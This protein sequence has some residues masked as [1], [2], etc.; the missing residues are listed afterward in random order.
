MTEDE[1]KT[2]WCPFA[3]SMV[4]IDGHADAAKTVKTGPIA[5]ASANRFEG[6]L[7]AL[8]V[9]SGCMAWRWENGY[10]PATLA[11]MR[12]ADITPAFPRGYCGLA[13]ATL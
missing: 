9:G 13:G 3:R 1:A 8:C 10:E 5:V 7:M 4:T 6:N 2:K 11:H 12:A